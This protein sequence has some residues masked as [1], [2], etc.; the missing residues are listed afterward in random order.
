MLKKK[1]KMQIYK[2]KN[3]KF[4]KK[5]NILFSNLSKPI[6]KMFQQTHTNQEFF[7][8]FIKIIQCMKDN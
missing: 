7:K 4:Q 1:E 6:F 5:S 8:K 3:K 2:Q